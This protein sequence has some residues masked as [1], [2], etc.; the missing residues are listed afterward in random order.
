MATSRRPDPTSPAEV[1][2][3]L[4]LTRR[5]L[6]YTTTTMCRL[7]GSVSHG[8]AYSNYE[9]GIR[10]INIQH[11]LKLCSRCRLTLPWIYQGQFKTLPKDIRE[12]IVEHLLPGD[13]L[14]DDDDQQTNRK[15]R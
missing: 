8:S 9:S 6:G 7:M 13:I 4:A 12:K 11:A 5:A 14:P 15:S 2:R 1:G 10:L 3:R